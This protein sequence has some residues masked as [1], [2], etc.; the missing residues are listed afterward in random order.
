MDATDGRVSLVRALRLRCPLC[1]HKPITAPGYGEIVQICP[2]CGYEFE[3]GEDGY[4]V[5]ALI[6]NMAVCLISFFV[7]LVG[8][9][10]LT[11]PDV[12]WT[13]LWVGSIAVMVL[14]PVWF[15]PR[16]KTVWVWLDLKIHPYGQGER[17]GR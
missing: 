12:P 10:L 17:P 6:V 4:Y 14:V 16:S 1:G 15:Y 7:T 2:G 5:G 9:M 11:W 13:G 8:T 3:Q